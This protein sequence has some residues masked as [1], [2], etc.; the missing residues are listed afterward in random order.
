[1]PVEK[2]TRAIPEGTS[3]GE[4]KNT[5]FT[6]TTVIYGRRKAVVTASGMDREF[7]KIAKEITAG[8]GERTPL[9]R[10]TQEIGK[11]LGLFALGICF[12]VAQISLLREMAGEALR[13]LALAC[14]KSTRGWNAPRRSW[15]GAWF[16]WA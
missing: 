13:V 5:V 8:E 16:S 7:G 1:M 12:F 15:K 3:V 14:R 9:E 2:E 11:W 6:G 4:Q 10:R